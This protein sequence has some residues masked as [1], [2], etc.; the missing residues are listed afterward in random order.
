M[1]YWDIFN[2]KKV[3]TVFFQI[4]LKP[5]NKT[6]ILKLCSIMFSGLGNTEK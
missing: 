5:K 6:Q 3:Q 2:S 1:F 4:T